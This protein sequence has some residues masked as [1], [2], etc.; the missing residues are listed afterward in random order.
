MRG[1]AALL[2]SAQ[3]AAGLWDVLQ[4]TG[5]CG[6][7]VELDDAT[8]EA[9]GLAGFTC[10]HMATGHGSIRALVLELDDQ[11]RLRDGVQRA[12]RKLTASAPHVLWIVGVVAP[13]ARSAGIVA[14]SI[15]DRSPRVASFVWGP[16]SLVDSDAETL[17][18]LSAIRDTTDLA[19][20][21]RCLE[22]LGRE[23][24]TRRFYRVLSSNVDAMIAASPRTMPHDEARSLALLCVSRLLFLRFLEAKSWLNGE[25]E[26]VAHRFDECMA[27]GGD[28]HRRVLLPLFFGTL[29]TR[30]ARRSARAR[31]FGRVPF[32]NGG[33]FART[34]FERRSHLRYPDERFGALLQEVFQRFR[35]VAREDTA[36]WS[37]ASVDPEMLGR[38]FESFMAT[39]DRRSGGVFYT[40]HALVERVAEHALAPILRGKNLA[41]L[42]DVRVLDPACGSGAFLV[43]VL[44]RLADHRR[45]LGDPGT[46][47]D[48]RRDVLARS[49]FG[50]DRNPTAVWLCELRLWLSVVIESDETDPMRVPPLPN[51][52]R[53]IRVG[54]ALAGAAFTDAR[55]SVSSGRFAESRKRYVRATGRR[56]AM[57]ARTLDR[58]ERQRALEET[59]RLIAVAR[60][61]RRELLIAQRARDLF[62]ERQRITA[63]SKLELGRTRERLRHHRLERI[64]IADGGALPFSFGAH[65]A[66]AQAAGGFD[67]VL[68]NPP[69]VRLHRI[70][71]E[72]RQRFRDTFEVFRSAHWQSGARSARA[73]TGFASQVDLSALFAE[74]S[75]ALLRQ[76]GMLSLL[77]P[78]KLWRSLSGGGIRR[79][80]TTHASLVRV[81]DA[82]E[83]KHTFDAVV[84][85]SMLVAR[86]DVSKSPRVTA[87]LHNAAGEDSWTTTPAALAF[88]ATPGAPWVLLPPKARDAFERLK[89]SGTPLA[90]TSFGSPRL[91]V[92]SGCNEAFL[93]R[94]VDEMRGLAAVIDANGD[95][96]CVE[97]AMLRPALKGDGLRAWRAAE[98][99]VHIIWT[100]AE[101]G[102]PL[103]QLPARTLAW[104]ERYRGAL[105][106]RADAKG[107]KRWWALFRTDA[108]EHSRA[109]VVWADFGRRPRALVLPRGNDTVPLNTCYV[110]HCDDPADAW[111]LAALLNSRVVAAWLNAIAEPARGG[112][113]RYLGWTVG[114]LPIPSRWTSVRESLAQAGKDVAA[115]RKCA[116][117]DECALAAFGMSQQA[118]RPL[119]NT[120]TCD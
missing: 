65:F 71:L 76:S 31:A 7:P 18:A 43:H 77:L 85:P 88:D 97:R 86:A 53:N 50:V 4:S 39:N 19:V 75:L 34:A 25:R 35:F 6:S 16:D 49:V 107:S 68:G 103:A 41:A 17:C 89:A 90:A 110:L 44:E 70:P 15:G 92:K 51:L 66:E 112:Y 113:R 57:L 120:V 95:T 117:L 73:A 99:P 5:L 46:V 60:H 24:L 64:R 28:F 78:A 32:L 80:L 9:L 40:P 23:A 62:G 94:R 37:E 13:G 42:R 27:A 11:S 36:S 116:V 106:H 33:L 109:R 26:F 20:H 55:F 111:A 108:A 48:T 82:S 38:A 96:G 67:V 47:A 58:M 105:A 81:E 56:K 2:S 74:R 54:D 91:G 115:G 3:S 59:D 93:V 102:A 84:Y 29:N 119:L 22:V 30:L 10:G 12:A 104:L 79:L 100:H 52:D 118:V 14:W 21:A 69:W 87:V 114:Q 101:S 98:S 72:T 61:A 1:A 63:E 45:H 8:C 83:A